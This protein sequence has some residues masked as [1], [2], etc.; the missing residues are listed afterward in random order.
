MLGFLAKISNTHSNVDDIDLLI[1][2]FDLI[3]SNTNFSHTKCTYNALKNW[4]K[5][6]QK[7]S[8]SVCTNVHNNLPLF[9]AYFSCSAKLTS[10]K[11]LVAALNL[12]ED[13]EEKLICIPREGR[14]PCHLIPYAGSDFIDHKLHRSFVKLVLNCSLFNSFQASNVNVGTH[15]TT[16]TQSHGILNMYSYQSHNH[17]ES[18]ICILIGI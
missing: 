9:S 13:K 2:T 5:D 8:T 3:L 12:V 1:L 10:S 6:S 18:L 16:I 15:I 7:S 11:G 4:Y 14:F 17:M